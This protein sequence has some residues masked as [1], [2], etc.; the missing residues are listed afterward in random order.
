MGIIKQHLFE[1]SESN[2]S[3]IKELA[4]YFCLED[5][6]ML[7]DLQMGAAQRDCDLETEIA[8]MEERMSNEIAMAHALSK[9]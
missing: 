6:D 5:D 1:E 9:D 8:L 2:E 3:R 7:A 4:L